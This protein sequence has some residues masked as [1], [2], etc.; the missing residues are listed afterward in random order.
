MAK[1][2]WEN[3]FNEPIPMLKNKTPREAAKTKEGREGS[4]HYYWCMSAV[5]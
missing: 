5:I 3:W 2:H 1:E 4:K